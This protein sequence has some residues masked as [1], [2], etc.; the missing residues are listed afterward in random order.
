MVIGQQ[1]ESFVTKIKNKIESF[2]TNLDL[3]SSDVI[4]LVSCFGIGFLCGLLL[5][6]YVKYFVLFVVFS[7]LLLATLHY[8]DFISIHQGQIKT[9]L[10]FSELESFDAIMT[11]IMTSIRIYAIELGTGVLGCLF[12][13]KVG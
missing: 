13:F 10:G 11:S 1:S 3:D 6:R 5:K 8:F 9:V 7:T 4:R 12:G 2:F